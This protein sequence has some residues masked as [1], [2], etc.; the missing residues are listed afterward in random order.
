MLVSPWFRREEGFD[1]V[2]VLFVC[3][4]NICRSPMAEAIF[5]HHAVAAGLGAELAQDSA[6]TSSWHVGEEPHAGTR[7]A[8]KQRGIACSHL[9]R[10]VTPDDLT[11]QDYLV[12]MDAANK[13]ELL[14]MGADAGRVSLLMDYVPGMAGED[15]PDPYYTGDFEHVYTLVDAGCRGLLAHIR[16]ARTT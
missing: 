15:V 2:Q 5:A 12:A 3:L 13:S 8:L 7:K 14:R 6:G 16:A 11:T 10:A 9:G 4:G 1:V